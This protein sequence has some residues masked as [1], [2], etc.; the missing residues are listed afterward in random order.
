MKIIKRAKIL[1]CECTICGSIFQPKLKNLRYST[2]FVKECVT[3]P[4][5]KKSNYIKFDKGAE[6]EHR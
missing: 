2:R 3:C 6:N 1:P 4:M 5:C